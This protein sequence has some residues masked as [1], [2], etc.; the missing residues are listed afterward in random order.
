MIY[1]ILNMKK[2]I[3]A[4]FVLLIVPGFVSAAMN[5]E[6]KECIQRGYS[7]MQNNCV[8]PDGT[9][10]LISEFNEGLCGSEYKTEDYCVKEG[11]S[12][13]DRDKCCP[14]LVPYLPSGMIGQATCQPI[15]TIIINNPYLYGL[16]VIIAVVIIVFLVIRKWKK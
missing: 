4:V 6:Y 16:L 12:V 1:P 3:F 9:E 14:G 11:V 5:P 10:C 2:I 15:Q 7:V 13:W 8:F